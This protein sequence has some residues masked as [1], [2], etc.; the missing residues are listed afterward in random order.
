MESMTRG[1]GWHFLDIGRRFERGIQLASLLQHGMVEPAPDEPSRLETVLEVS[2]S[3]MTYRSRYVTSVQA[4][5]A[6]DLL[7]LDGA[8]PRGMVFQL[9]RLHSHFQALARAP[10]TE[11]DA[12]RDDLR[13]ASPTELVELEPPADG[14]G[15]PRRARL[16]RLLS[17]IAAALPELA[18]ALDHAYLSHAI[19]RR[20][21]ARVGGTAS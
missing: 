9:E 15:R 20:Q 16:G 7:L 18:A 12:L 14:S 8:N 6:L 17:A 1:M 5:L 3:T 11:L 2:D 10:L 21:S 13:R 19:P 4:P